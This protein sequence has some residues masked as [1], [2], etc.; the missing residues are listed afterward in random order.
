MQIGI[1]GTIAVLRMKDKHYAE[2]LLKGKM[3]ETLVGEMLKASGNTVYSFGFETIT[4]NLVQAET[5]FDKYCDVGERVRAIPDFIVIDKAGKPTLVEVKF[6][7]NP[8]AEL[9]EDTI[10]LL[11]RIDEYWK[12][13]V[14]FV[15]CVEKPYF[16]I[17]RP[18]YFKNFSQ[19][20]RGLGFEPLMSV[21]EWNI[22]PEVYDEHEALVEKYLTPTMRKEAE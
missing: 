8:T 18:P 9:H 3:T 16:R 12:A 22:A 4:Q 10:A 2:N 13:D 19:P 11:E 21:A 15:N 7:W 20:K 6:R 1:D 14:L 17:C 5:S